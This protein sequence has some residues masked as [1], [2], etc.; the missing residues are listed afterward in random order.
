MRN[1][2]TVR[3]LI[4]VHGR[5]DPACVSLPLSRRRSLES[6]VHRKVPAGFGGGHAEKGLHSRHLAAWPTQ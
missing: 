5:H 2:T 4:R 6:L 1:A 3:G